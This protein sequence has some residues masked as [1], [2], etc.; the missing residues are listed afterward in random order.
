MDKIRAEKRGEKKEEG[1]LSLNRRGE[2]RL[3]LFG[4]HP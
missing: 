3:A 1:K 2:V 4:G